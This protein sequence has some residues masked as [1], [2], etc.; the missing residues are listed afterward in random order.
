MAPPKKIPQPQVTVVPAQAPRSWRPATSQAQASQQQREYAR[1]IAQWYGAG[2]PD[3]RPVVSN[4]SPVQH[5]APL[6]K[7]SVTVGQRVSDAIGKVA[8][9]PMTMLLNPHPL[10]SAGR[11]WSDALNSGAD[12]L[13]RGT[14][15]SAHPFWTAVRN[16]P[17]GVSAAAG[18]DPAAAREEMARGKYG[19]AVAAYAANPIAGLL[20]ALIDPVAGEGAEAAVEGIGNGLRDR[21]TSIAQKL[22]EGGEDVPKAAELTRAVQEEGPGTSVAF[23]KNG[24]AGNINKAADRSYRNIGA[25]TTE[26]ELEQAGK[27][28]E[29][30][31]LAKNRAAETSPG[32]WDNAQAGA[33]DALRGILRGDVKEVGLGVLSAMGGTA[34]ISRLQMQHF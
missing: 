23:T 24:Y 13:V 10:R 26:P 17:N 30:A 4:S 31:T 3:V 6:G 2:M 33:T 27:L 8:L 32:I 15:D 25:Q 12:E 5:N 16:L 28:F 19:R 21:G 1:E 29:A 7:P 22:L 11:A 34:P 9:S 20:P 18:G 14:S